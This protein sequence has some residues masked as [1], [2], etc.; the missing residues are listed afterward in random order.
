M[1][2][3]QMIDKWKQIHELSRQAGPGFGILIVLHGGDRRCSTA[4][5]SNI[6]SLLNRCKT[7][8]QNMQPIVISIIADVSIKLAY[9]I[10]TE[11]RPPLTLHMQH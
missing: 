10:V 2:R 11:D 5:S 7:R 4:D 8:C 6:S 3:S 9:M 1:K